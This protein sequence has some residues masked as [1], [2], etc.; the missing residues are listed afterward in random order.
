[1][2]AEDRPRCPAISIRSSP[3]KAGSKSTPWHD[4]FDLDHGH[5]RYFGDHK[6][7]TALP[8]GETRGNRALLEQLRYHRGATEADRMQATPLLVFRAVT[9]DGAHKGFLEFCGLGLLEKAELIV[10]WDERESRSYPNY[11]F[12]IMILDI[13]REDESV[14]WAW[15]NSRRNPSLSDQATL[16]LA[17]WSW[18]TWVK[19]GDTALPKIRRQVA[20][21][22]VLS[23]REQLPDPSSPEHRVLESIYRSFDGRKA[24]FEALASMVAGRVIDGGSGRYTPGWLTSPTGDRGVDFVGRLDA[25]SEDATAHLVVLGQAKCISPTSSVSAEQLS[26]IVARL[27]R[28]WIGAYVTTGT[29]SRGAQLEMLEDDY[30]VVMVNGL[31]LSREVRTMAYESYGGDVDQLL[32]VSAASAETLITRRRPEEVLWL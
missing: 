1:M 32:A 31:R 8:L 2:A 12:D 14:D 19:E 5:V 15:I 11:V 27:K 16:R 29:Y 17:P 18:R 26:R 20:R 21:N 28:G 6:S 30:P 13:A 25:G 9:V 3:W 23:S 10:H 24:T 7:T 4:V 22:R